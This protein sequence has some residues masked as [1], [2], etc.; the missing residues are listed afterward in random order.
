M[1]PAMVD[2]SVTLAVGDTE[3]N[4]SSHLALKTGL[5]FGIV[6]GSMLLAQPM[7]NIVREVFLRIRF[8]TSWDW[9][10]LQLHGIQ[11]WLAA[12][13][14]L[15]QAI[16][17]FFARHGHS[18]QVAI[19]AQ[20]MTNILVLCGYGSALMAYQADKIMSKHIHYFNVSAYTIIGSMVKR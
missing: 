5:M 13:L 19:M 1:L 14:L 4:G 3:F 11:I 12:S 17:L 18:I 20:N 15:P 10:L 7:P 8:R 9:Q 2:D 6:L 16:A